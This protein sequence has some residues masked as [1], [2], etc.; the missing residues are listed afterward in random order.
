MKHKV[1]NTLKTHSMLGSGSRVI[2]ALSGGADS[3][4]LFH[5]IISLREELGIEVYA[6]HVNH[7]L[8]GQESLRDEAFVKKLCKDYNVELFIKSV[9]VNAICAE[10][11]ESFETVGRRVRY[12]FFKELSEK[13]DAEVA[14]AHTLSDSLETA[15]FNMARGASF[16]G[17]S[18]IPYKRG[19]VIRPLLDVTRKE[20]EFYAK[21]NKLSYVDDSTNA[22]ADIC[23]RNKIRHKAVPVLK[24]VN[25]GAEQNYLRLRQSLIDAEAFIKTEAEKLISTAECEFGYDAKL[26]SE[27][28]PAPLSYALKLILEKEDAGFEYKHIELIK[29]SLPKGGAVPLIKGY[30]A[31]VK[32]GVLRIVCESKA[33]KGYFPFKINSSFTY[34][35][36]IYS[37]KELSQEEIINK[38]LALKAIGYDKISSDANFRTRQSG[39]KFSLLK[40]K[41]TKDLRKLQNELKIPSEKRDKMLLLQSGGK[42]LWAEGVGVS[43]EGMY[44]EGKG[45]LIE[46]EKEKG[47][48]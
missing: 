15:L 40:R 22:D 21:D 24:E 1:L 25:E 41:I 19:R 17:L 33:Q 20:V 28:H 26:L 47:Y 6:A 45:I 31:I 46:V 44:T 35:G 14:T 30:I 2:I 32:Q 18:S 34:D 3:V 5:V 39:D 38:K 4:T 36:N 13:L 16:A 29:S 7:N 10:T 11:S 27:A 37:V 43:L 48:A 42:V 9:D 12:E 8:R 23:N